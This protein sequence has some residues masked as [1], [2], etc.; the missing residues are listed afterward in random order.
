LD[1]LRD[2]P[3]L[4]LP[5]W[6]HRHLDETG[7]TNTDCIEAARAGDHGD[8][9]ITAGRQVSG[10]GRLGRQWV[11]EVG[12]LYA[13]ALILDAAP[14]ARLST[15]PF[16]SALAL[17][18]TLSE[19][20]G[21]DP[22]RIKIKWPNDI[23]ID[24]SK[25]S[26]LLIESEVLA[27]GAHAIA[28]GFGVNVAH[29]PDAAQYPTTDLKTLGIAI[30]PDTLFHRLALNF[31]SILDIWNRGKGFA[32]IREEWLRHAKGIGEPITVN[33]P[34]EQLHGTFIDIDAQG[35]LVFAGSMGEERIIS[36]GDIFFPAQKGN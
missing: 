10:R 30:T 13:S 36:A 28:C 33:L 1:S 5:Q 22:K 11:S 3:V 15:L 12:N 34:N 25:I 19:K 27:N 23:L 26:G 2:T 14:P 9:W 16:V 4:G 20:S 17:H 6:R 31:A 32:K 18:A 29:H 8:L 24:G 7:S 21:L 35:C